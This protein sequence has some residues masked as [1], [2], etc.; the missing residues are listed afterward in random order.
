ME[1]IILLIGGYGSVGRSLTNK[2]LTADKYGLRFEYSDK[3]IDEKG[4]DSQDNQNGNDCATFVVMFG[5]SANSPELGVGEEIEY[6]QKIKHCW[7]L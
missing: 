1:V 3:N 5:L 6:V 2:S 7:V 4:S